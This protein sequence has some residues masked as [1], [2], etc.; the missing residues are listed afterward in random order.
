M[1]P[2]QP[3]TKER[4]R[5]PTI[6]KREWPK[7]E[8]SAFDKTSDQEASRVGRKS[9]R[10][11]TAKDNPAPAISATPGPQNRPHPFLQLQQAQAN[12]KGKKS[13]IFS[14][15]SSTPSGRGLK[16]RQNDPRRHVA[17]SGRKNSKG[18][19]VQTRIASVAQ[20]KAR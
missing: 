15:K 3:D 5:F 18:K 16:Q 14:T 6:A 12:P 19:R 7:S 1:P 11:S 13:R 17:V 2:S 9:C 4:T 20:A 8:P 10:N